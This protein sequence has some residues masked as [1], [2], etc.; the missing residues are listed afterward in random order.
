MRNNKP[1]TFEEDIDGTGQGTGQGQAGSKEENNIGDKENPRTTMSST[2]NPS[3]SAPSSS[4]PNG[5]LANNFEYGQNREEVGSGKGGGN[6]ESAEYTTYEID[7]GDKIKICR[8]DGQEHTE[9]DTISVGNYSSQEN[10]DSK[11]NSIGVRDG[12]ESPGGGD[13]SNSAKTRILRATREIARTTDQINATKGEIYR[14][15]NAIFRTEKQIDFIEK[16]IIDMEGSGIDYDPS[17]GVKISKF[18]ALRPQK[19]K[20]YFQKPAHIKH[21]IDDEP[22]PKEGLAIGIPFFNEPSHEL[23]Q[24]LIS[25]HESLKNLINS[26]RKWSKKPIY[27]NI[28]QDGWHKAHESMKRY[29]KNMFPCKINNI[30]W[31]DY[32]DEF[33][34]G[35]DKDHPD[36]ET[37]FVFEKEFYEPV[38]INPQKEFAG[39]RKF[40]RITLLIKITNRKKHNSHEWFLGHSGFAEAVNP[41]YL[42]LTDAFTLFN[43]TCLYHLIRQM[44]GDNKIS[45]CTGRQRLMSRRQQGSTESLF[46]IAYSL[47]MVQL[48]DFEMSNAVYNGAFSLGGFLPVIPGP[49]G[50]YRASDML[51]DEPRDWY[52]GIV[53]EEPDKTGLVLGNLRIA[54][55]RILSASAAWKTE[56]QKKMA[57]NPLALFYFEAETEL[58]MFILQRRRWINGSVAGYVYFLLSRFQNFRNWD[59]GAIRK[60]YIW[61]LLCSQ[62]LIYM[63]VGIAPGI[64]LKILYFGIL[65]F[66]D[67]YN[68]NFLT[69]TGE[70]ILLVILFGLYIMHMFI[71]N[72]NKFNYVIMF[73]LYFLSIVTSIMSVSALVH[74]ILVDQ[75]DASAY[76]L[77]ITDGAVILLLGIVIF[78]LPFIN[79]AM[80]S[81]K[82]HS[83]AYMAKS[84]VVY[85]LLTQLM[86][87][88]FGSYAYSRIWDL[89]WGN[90]PSSE[91]TEV[92]E[93]DRKRMVNKF[94]ER[95]IILI[96]FLIICNS[97]VFILPIQ[98]IF[99][100]M[101]T[102]YLIASFQMVLSFVFC[103]TKLWYKFKF[104]FIKCC[105]GIKK[106]S[107]LFRP[108]TYRRMD[109]V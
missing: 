55:D 4:V 29:L 30:N 101:C 25:L 39:K 51:R 8:W 17:I 91:L 20:V 21:W 42:F 13:R 9:K 56:G 63:L 2:Q 34:K 74:Y 7:A 27:V 49:C 80:L 43:T 107:I 103:L 84:F 81:G 18:E 67:Y 109:M 99:V 95:S 61:I 57:F 22:P 16:K 83:V 106:R 78:F 73:L 54:E 62:L 59:A 23:E 32:Y 92:N 89:S 69:D 60:A 98:A 96:L 93:D 76:K 87:A 31:W 65:Y 6:R 33:K 46:S 45:A 75:R 37:V 35:Y 48:Y 5:I 64:S 88:W 38:I 66:L 77:F 102:F 105:V 47:R 15:E 50:L 36:C 94:K 85:F 24:T 1:R 104:S 40:M 68:I 82:W 52:F 90:R 97:V 108:N 11:T 72:R 28:L 100:I 86:I 71:H 44:D 14:A 12:E 41:E 70:I 53:N 19:G 10:S 58:K 26:S 3:S 79:A